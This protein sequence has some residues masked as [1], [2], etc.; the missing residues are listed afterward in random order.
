MHAE[1]AEDFDAAAVLALVGAEAQL[2]VGFDGIVALGLE[3]V[4]PDLV[5]EADTASLLI[6]VHENAAP[7]GRDPLEGGLQLLAAVTLRRVKDVPGQTAR[8]QAYQDI[9]AVT[10]LAVNGRNMRL[11]VVLALVDVNRELAVLCGQGR[12]SDAFHKAG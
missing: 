2:L 11:A 9:A 5:R 8:M 1:I 7:F 12:R 10:E 3:R 4:G 6:E